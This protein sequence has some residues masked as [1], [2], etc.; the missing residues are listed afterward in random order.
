M[1]GV[2]YFENL[3]LQSEYMIVDF[4]WA[5]LLERC[6]Y[7]LVFFTVHEMENCNCLCFKPTVKVLSTANLAVININNGAQFLTGLGTL[8]A[9]TVRRV[10][11]ISGEI[12]LPRRINE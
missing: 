7:K 9:P 12:E 2:D 5:C 11:D 4:L 6:S 8:F 3:C 1:Q 10:P